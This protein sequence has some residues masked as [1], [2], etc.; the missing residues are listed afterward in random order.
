MRTASHQRRQRARLSSATVTCFVW[1]ALVSLT[2]GGAQTRTGTIEGRVTFEGMIPAP[3]SVAESGADQPV[4]HVDR[5][6][7]LRYAVV[8]LPDAGRQRASSLAPVT[9]NQRRFV[10][11]PPVLAVRAGQLVRFTNAD[12]AN[13]NV[14]AAS[15]V[16]ENVFSVNTAPGAVA[17]ERRFAAAPPEQPIALTCDIHP[18]MAAWVY[19][20]DHGQFALTDAEG[21]FRIERVPEGRHRFAVR[22]PA[23]R[24]ARN[25]SVDVTAGQVVRVDVRFTDADIGLPVR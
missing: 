8:Y 3:L 11:E 10:F 22:Q 6:G 19:V 2:S 16:P 4:L 24:L 25:L 1:T 5:S 23:G 13:H 12:S 17:A 7:G 21:T 14:R 9:L 20:F 15:G 18:W